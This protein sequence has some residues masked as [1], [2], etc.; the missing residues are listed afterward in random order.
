[1]EVLMERLLSVREFAEALG[2]TVS[3]ARRWVLERK[4]AT[5]K[6]G[7]LIR[8]P[9]SEC[10][11]LISAGLRPARQHDSNSRRHYIGHERS[12]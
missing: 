11:R 7:R 12:V 6:L 9:A 4:I 5:T 10:E 2:V 1:M 8:I 3:C